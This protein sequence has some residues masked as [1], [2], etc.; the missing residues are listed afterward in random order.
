MEIKNHFKIPII[1]AFSIKDIQDLGDVDKY[2]SIADLF[3]FDTKTKNS[4][5]S[6][7]TFDWKI[8]QNFTTKKDW[9]L[10][11]GLNTNNIEEALKI[12]NTK[13]VDLSSGIEEVRGI[14]SPEL[15]KQF[16]TKISQF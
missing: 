1:K 3:L 14:K 12:T 4:G 7:K 2:E 16:M 10:S 5:G 11:G 13:M 9:F 15:I 8:L 6:G